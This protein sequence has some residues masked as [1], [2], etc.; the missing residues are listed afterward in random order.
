MGD[1]G[2]RTFTGFA[3]FDRVGRGP[4]EAVVRSLK[5]RVDA[6]ESPRVV[7]YDDTTGRVFE[8]DWRGSAD[9]VVA[10]LA[11]PPSRPPA[12][13]AERRGPGRPRLGVVARE[14]SLLPRHWEWLAT[15]PGGASAAL[16]RLVDTARRDSQGRDRERSV[17]EAVHRFLW[18]LA[19]NL[20]QFEE[21]TRALERSE[22]T[23]ADALVAEWPAGVR[24]HLAA[25]TAPLRSQP[26]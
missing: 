25:L 11:G 1:D 19:A 23:R 24:E 13:D 10:R 17:R 5:A 22:W 15:Q 12:E 20:P 7:V 18:D 14:V 26:A 21:V 3:G 8:V 4:L 6:G 16:R 9:E 2:E